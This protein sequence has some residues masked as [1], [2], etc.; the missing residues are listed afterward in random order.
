MNEV[1]QLLH[2]MSNESGD[3]R[4]RLYDELVT[5]VY[6]DLKRRAVQ[7]IGGNNAAVYNPQSWCTKHTNVF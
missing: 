4:K 5:I 3:S 6:G 2:Q 1:T 7:Q